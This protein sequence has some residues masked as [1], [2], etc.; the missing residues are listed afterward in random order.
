M[1][2]S[3]WYDAAA[4]DERRGLGISV[5]DERT[6]LEP[7][8]DDAGEDQGSMVVS[9]RPAVTWI[10]TGVTTNHCRKYDEPG[11]IVGGIAVV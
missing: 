6:V 9:S 8:S 2:W 10:E 11:G 4:A 5:V 7:P 3:A 1:R